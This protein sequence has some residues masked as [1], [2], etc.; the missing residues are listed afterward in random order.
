MFDNHDDAK[1]FFY[2]KVD[3]YPYVEEPYRAESYG[4]GYLKKGS[5]KM[6]SGL[7]EKV[8]QA[9]SL[10]TLGPTVIRSFSKDNEEM[11]M[12]IIFFKSD[13][14]LENQANVFFLMQFDFFEN[15]DRHVFQL[16]DDTANTF[17]QL[18]KQIKNTLDTGNK[19]EKSIM[20]SYLY[21]LIYEIDVI[22]TLTIT[23]TS[24]SPIFGKFRH[25]L[26]QNFLR[27]R[28]VGF[29][30]D[31]LNV[32]RKYLTEVIKKHSGKTASEWIDEAVILEAKVLLKDKSLTISQISNMLN[33][34]DQSVFGKFFKACVKISPL[35]YRNRD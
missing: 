15:S 32:S 4:I 17:G 26:M 18:F 33:F 3:R 29:Y 12:D 8:V 30:A 25:S 7:V 24:V 2:A 19:H 6:N 35:E 21:I 31:Q 34:S 13:F 27:Q 5:I 16:T 23:E 1:D 10:I 14:F 22:K 20:R 11:Q 9:P 28:S